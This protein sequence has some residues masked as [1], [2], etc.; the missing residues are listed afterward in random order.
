M[1]MNLTRELRTN[2]L[3]LRRWC[4]D[5][6]VPFA[7][8]N[9]DPRVVEFFPGALSRQ[10]SDALAERIEAQFERHGF[11][12]WAVEIPGISQFAGFIGLS[13]PRFEAHFTPCIEIGWRLD[14]EHWNQGYATEGARAALTFHC[15]LRK[16]SHSPFR[17]MSAQGGSWRKSAWLTRPAT[18]LNTRCCQEG[19]R[20]GATFCTGSGVPGSARKA[21]ER[22]GILTR[23][24]SLAAGN[25]S[26][27]EKGFRTRRDRVGQR[28]IR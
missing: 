13:I 25:G 12:L 2:R 26:D 20:S 4:L 23:F 9:S 16:S 11:G 28:S 7:K 27:D 21:S 18:T 1:K 6:R 19:T 10:E 3:W 8:L 5:D 14:S 22:N 17:P 15:R 24:S